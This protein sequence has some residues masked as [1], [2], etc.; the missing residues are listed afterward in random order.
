M[1]K[2]IKKRCIMIFPKFENIQIIN[3]IREIYDPVVNNVKPHITLV[4]PFESSIGEDEL[5]KWL[6]VTLKNTRCF[7]V[8]VKDVIKI[9]SDSMFYLCLEVK[10]GRKEIKKISSKLYRGILKE[11]KPKW[12]NHVEFIP[13]MT[14]GKFTNAEELNSAYEEISSLKEKFHSKVD[15]VSVEIVIENDVAIREIEVD[16]LK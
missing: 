12:L 8:E 6:T 7:E 1:G 11:Y 4:F 5:R 2:D 16:L 3:E 9:S 15:K 13:H 10:K 14:I